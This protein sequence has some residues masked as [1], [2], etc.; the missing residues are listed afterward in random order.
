MVQ[1]RALLTTVRA[2]FAAGS[3]SM[4]WSNRRAPSRCGAAGTGSDTTPVP[5]PSAKGNTTSTDWNSVQPVI[6]A[7]D[8]SS[9]SGTHGPLRVRDAEQERGAGGGGWGTLQPLLQRLA[10]PGQA[11][12]VQD[13]PCGPGA[14][15]ERGTVGRSLAEVELPGGAVDDEHEAATGEV[16][17]EHR[18]DACGRTVR[19]RLPNTVHEHH[20]LRDGLLDV[21]VDR[22]HEPA[23]GDHGAAPVVIGDRVPGA[24]QRAAAV[25]P[26]GAVPFEGR[27]EAVA[28][29]PRSSPGHH[30]DAAQLV[31]GEGRELS[32]RQERVLRL[33]HVWPF[34][35]RKRRAPDAQ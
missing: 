3:G 7:N 20:R 9:G 16:V 22:A 27:I 30:R 33:G 35:S 19:Q 29:A 23:E 32:E 6:P 8:R 17:G 5:F 10:E 21:A 28:P 18:I 25:L 4:H 31:V 13:E 24:D 15:G 12:L 1:A 34:H 14:S 2:G 26:L 11:A